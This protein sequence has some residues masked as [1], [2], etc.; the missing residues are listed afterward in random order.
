MTY[1]KTSIY[2]ITVICLIAADAAATQVMSVQVKSGQVRSTPS[3]MGKVVA[4]LAYGDQ[5]MTGEEQGGWLKVQVPG[6]GIEGWMHNSALSAKK[7]ELKAGTAN[8]KQT[9]SGQ[10]L[11]LAGKGFNKQVENEFKAKHPNMDFRWID[12]MERFQVTPNEMQKFLEQ[13][14]LR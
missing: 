4:D 7:I 9:A 6:R 2:M 10:E 5:V 3:F 14:G 11:A 13:G 12:Q 1:I 8:V